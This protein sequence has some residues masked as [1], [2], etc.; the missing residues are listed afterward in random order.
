MYSNPISISV[1]NK[2]MAHGSQC[3]IANT[4]YRPPNSLESHFLLKIVWNRIIKKKKRKFGG[5][6]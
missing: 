5:L 4:C 2:R 6:V 1:L 3:E